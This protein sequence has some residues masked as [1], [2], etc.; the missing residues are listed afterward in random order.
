[1]LEFISY[2]S[3]SAGNLYE[4]NDGKTR[5]LIECGLPWKQMQKLTEHTL[6]EFAACLVSHRHADHYNKKSADMLMKR[7]V[8]VCVGDEF[9]T[10]T[11]PI[12]FGGNN[13]V[14]VKTFNV[15]HDVPNYGFIIRSPFT[16]ETLVFMVDCFYS[17]VRFSFSP[18]IIA[19]E[20][21]YSRDLMRPGDSLNDRLF[22]SHMSLEQCIKTLLS[23]DL[24]QT[25]EIHLLH[26]SDERSDEA[27]FIREVQG[28]TGVPTYVAQKKHKHEKESLKKTHTFV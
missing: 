8:D 15:P 11:Q 20:C 26:L 25:R 9:K 24:S 12:L 10:E 28:A 4:L 23:W 27:R 14:E 21:N 19:I 7:G 22:S 13:P 18:T 5:I 2:A 1:M 6:S 3:S 17:P 16:K